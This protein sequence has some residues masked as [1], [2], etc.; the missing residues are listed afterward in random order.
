VDILT[1]R[2]SLP[3]KQITGSIFSA[4][5]FSPAASKSFFYPPTRQYYLDT[6]N[7]Y[8]RIVHL[9]GYGAD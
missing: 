1:I 5:N 2:G 8:M 3:I 7:P 4:R 9:I 6:K